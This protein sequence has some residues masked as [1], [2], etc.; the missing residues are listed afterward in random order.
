MLIYGLSLSGTPPVRSASDHHGPAAGASGGLDTEAAGRRTHPLD[1]AGS[2][3]RERAVPQQ[4]ASTLARARPTAA[5]GRD[6]QVH[7]GS[8]GR[9]EDLRRRGAVPESAVERRRA[10]PRREDP[11]SSAQPH[12]A[13]AAVAPWPARAPNARLRPTRPDE[14]VRRLGDPDGTCARRVYA[15][16]HRR[17]VLGLPQTRDPTLSRAGTAYYSR[18]LVDPLHTTGAGLAGRASLGPVPLHAERR[19]VAQHGRG[20]VQHSDAQVGAPWLF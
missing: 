18:Q 1:H 10:Q 15:A 7:R 14:P 9:G 13:P 12:T 3:P 16:P 4:R 2:R 6:L 17:R 11:D 8:G 19:V 5:P 20:V